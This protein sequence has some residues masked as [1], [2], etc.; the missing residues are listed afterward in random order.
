MFGTDR[1]IRTRTV[2]GLSLLPLPVGVRQHVMEDSIGFEP[3]IAGLQSAGLGR[4]PKSPYK[5]HD[6]H[7]L[8]QECH[9]IGMH[10]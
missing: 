10:Y 1:E 7:F 5:G 9:T 3:M 6:L 8:R 4:L 2:Q